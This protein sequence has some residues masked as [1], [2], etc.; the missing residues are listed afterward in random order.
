MTMSKSPIPNNGIYWKVLLTALLIVFT[1]GGLYVKLNST[2]ERVTAQEIIVRE[3]TVA[4]A[5]IKTTLVY[6]CTG[7]DE[8]R[9][10]KA[11]KE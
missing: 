2:T 8:L 5:E 4:I 10:I 3:N 1:C 9:G 7:V 11:S 6:I